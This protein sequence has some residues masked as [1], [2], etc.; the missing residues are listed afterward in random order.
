M[1]LLAHTV[2]LINE[3]SNVIG[4]WITGTVHDYVN[5]KLYN[6]YA[7]LKDGLHP[8]D[9]TKEVWAKKFVLA[10]MKNYNNIHPV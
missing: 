2:N 1:P 9:L 3:S 6:R 7:R 5:H 10:I 4:P 8:T